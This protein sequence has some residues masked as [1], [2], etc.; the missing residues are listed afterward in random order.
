MFLV[1]FAPALAAEAAG[2]RT[3]SDPPNVIIIYSDDHGYTDLGIYGIDSHVNTPNMDAL[4][5]NGALMRAGYSS[6]PQCRPSRCGLLTGRIQNEFGFT[7]NKCDAGAGEGT[8]P[9]VYPQGTDMAGKPLLTIAERM[10]KLG[11]VTGFS[12]KWH[13]GPN[14]DRDR[15]FD[16][17][18][19][20][21]DDYWVAPMTSGVANLDL[22]GQSIPHQRKSWPGANRVI[23]QGKYAEAFVRKNKDR[24]FFLYLPIYGPHVPMIQKDDLYVR[25]TALVD[26]P[27]Y[28]DAQDKHRRLGLALIKAMDDAIGGLVATLQRFGLDQNTLILFS[29]DN[30][31]PGRFDNGAIGAWNGSNNVPMRGP[32]GTLHEGG[33]RVPMF[34][35]WKGRIKPGTVIEEMVTTLDFTATTLAVAGGEIPPEFDGLN[36]MPRLNG[37]QQE[38]IRTQPM[39]WDFYTGQAIRDGDWKLWRNNEITVLFNIAEDPAELTN[40]A[41]KEPKRVKLLK[42]KLNAWSESLRPSA[43][44]DPAGRGAKLAPHFAGAPSEIQPD[45]RY[46]IPYSTPKAAPYP[47][48]VR[49]PGAAKPEAWELEQPKTQR[50][51]P[52]KT[53]Q[54]SRD[55]LFRSRDRNRDGAITLEE[56]IG[57]P[58]GRNVP[59]LTNRFNKLDRNRNS[60][61]ELDELQN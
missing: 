14:E 37:Q 10:K 17:R 31:A 49:S 50:V 39:Y 46:L 52:R 42:E 13:C 2:T 35:S 20:G 44:Y 32:K 48:A 21:F 22:K 45:P 57:N 40:L 12:G 56:F 61:L 27:Q 34:A 60:K 5:R 19:R 38:I 47:A 51:T 28:N 18:G 54:R 55:Q 15:K 58:K 29:G 3:E 26:Y 30:G 53:N 24:P 25:N 7:D 4:A 43:R 6:A 1:T 16:P 23:L 41:W 59:A 11:Y 9:R 36:L 8:L 33:I